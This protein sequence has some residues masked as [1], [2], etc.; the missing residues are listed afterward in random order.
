MGVVIDWES[1][2]VSYSS[3]DLFSWTG[4]IFFLVEMV[5]IWFDLLLYLDE[6][7]FFFVE[8][9]G[10][11]GREGLRGGRRGLR[12]GGR[13][14]N[15]V[16]RWRRLTCVRV[17]LNVEVRLLFR[18]IYTYCAT[19]RTR[20]RIFGLRHEELG[21]AKTAVF[22]GREGL[23]SWPTTRGSRQLRLC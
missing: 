6:R 14:L 19:P 2:F 5:V 11:G 18:H 9:G 20:H 12:G 13:G 17:G 7:M 16:A 4:F 8:G 23:T 22:D 21:K 3:A 1:L 10:W 15:V